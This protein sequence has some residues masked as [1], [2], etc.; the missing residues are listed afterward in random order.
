MVQALLDLLGSTYHYQEP[1]FIHILSTILPHKQAS[2]HVTCHIHFT[3]YTLGYRARVH[4][5]ER[6]LGKAHTQ[7]RGSRQGFGHVVVT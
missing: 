1:V 7:V 3:F 6:H 5:D 4:E 2:I